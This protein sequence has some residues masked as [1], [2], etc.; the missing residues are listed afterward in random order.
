MLGDMQFDGSVM[1]GSSLEIGAVGAVPNTMH[2]C[3]LA[4]QVLKRLPH[5]ILVGDGARRFA[6]EVGIP[7]VDMLCEDSSKVWHK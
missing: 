1:D 5:N 4:H 6:D 3:Q 7:S 2:V